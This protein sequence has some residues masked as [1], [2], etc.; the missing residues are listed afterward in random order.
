MIKKLVSGL[1][2]SLVVLLGFNGVSEAASMSKAYDDYNA[3]L[4]LETDADRYTK[5][6]DTV[7]FKFGSWNANGL[8]GT[9]YWKANLQV[10]NSSGSWVSV[11]QTHAG[12]ITPTSPSK[13]SWN[14]NSF[15]WLIP[16]NGYANYGNF[17]IKM[18]MTDG[19]LK[20][21]IYYTT[22]FRIDKQ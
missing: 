10:R 13:R 1:V 12:Y 7:D 22:I 18:Q 5:N 11:G 6:A 3:N 17:R 4:F 14:I 8:V 21:K 9:N 20:G 19:H 2:L 16:Q 15:T